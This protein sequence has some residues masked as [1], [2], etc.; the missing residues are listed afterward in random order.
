MFPETTELTVS[1]TNG[2]VPST[3]PAALRPLSPVTH[4]T[5]VMQPSV[6]FESQPTA[7]IPSLSEILSDI[8]APFSP[9]ASP[10]TGTAQSVCTSPLTERALRYQRREASR[11]GRN[12]VASTPF[13]SPTDSPDPLDDLP[14]QTHHQYRLISTP[15]R[16]SESLDL[17]IL[18]NISSP[19]PEQYRSTPTHSQLKKPFAH[20][21]PAT[22]PRMTQALHMA[23]QRFFPP[24]F[25]APF[26][27]FPSM[28]PREPPAACLRLRPPYLPPRPSPKDLG[29]PPSGLLPPAPSP[30]DT[31][32]GL[33][34]L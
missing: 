24:A 22:F 13:P 10:E 15:A 32:R 25:A 8:D 5:P 17:T 6:Q 19:G 11:T 1:P 2:L 26:A 7:A 23:E 12:T 27:P 33:P 4:S 30:T 20:S 21:T 31:P 28:I 29:P 14:A 16:P 9:L 3:I 34:H 18:S